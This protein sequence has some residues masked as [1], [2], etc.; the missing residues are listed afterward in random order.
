VTGQRALADGAPVVYGR[1]KEA[2]NSSEFPLFPLGWKGNLR[3]PLRASMGQAEGA[4]LRAMAEEANVRVFMSY[5]T[6]PQV[7]TALEPHAIVCHWHDGGLEVWLSTQCIDDMAADIA[8]AAGL[9]RDRV[10]VHAEHIGGGFGAKANFDAQMLACI[11]LAKE[12]QRPVRMLNSRAEELSFAGAR[13]AVQALVSLAATRAGEPA[14]MVVEAWN[15]GGACVGN[16]TGALYRLMYPFAQKR[17]AEWDV[18]SNAPIARAMRGPGGPAATFALESAMDGLAQNLGITPLALRQKW[19]PS[20]LRQ[21]LYAQAAALPWYATPAPR[22]DGRFRT[23]VGLASG[24]WPYFFQPNTRISLTLEGGRL[25]AR[26]ATQDMGNGTRTVIAA[27]IA[28]RLGIDRGLVTV[29]IGDSSYPPGPMSGGSRTTAS[30]GPVAIDATDQLAGELVDLAAHSFSLRNARPGKGGVDHDA[31]QLPWSQVFASA[32]RI[33]VTGRRKR[34]PAGRF[35]PFVVA[36]VAT[37]K[38]LA[39]GVQVVEVEVDTLLGRVRVTRSWTGIAC[40]RI[41]SPQLAR[42]QVCGG[43]VQGIGYAL[44]EERRIDENSGRVVTANLEDYRIPGIADIPAL[45]VHFDEEGFEDVI[46]EGIGMSELC[47]VPVSAAVGNAIFAATG[48][49]PQHLPIRPDKVLRFPTDAR[50]AVGAERRAGATDLSDRRHLGLH[51]GEVV[52]LRDVR[53]LRGIERTSGGLDIG[54]MVTI[55]ELAQHPEVLARLPGLAQAAG[56]LATPQIRAV[57]TVGG[58]LLQ[59]TRCNHF[60]AGDLRCRKLGGSGC[61][62]RDGDHLWHSIFLTGHCIAPHPST[63]AVALLAYNALVVLHNGRVLSIDA[64][65]GDGQAADREH[66]L[67]VDELLTGVW[68]PDPPSGEHAIWLRA[69]SRA[70]AEWPLVEVVVRQ[71]T[72]GIRIAA[73]GVSPVPV[74]LRA[75]EEALAEGVHLSAAVERAADGHAALPQNAYKA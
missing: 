65:Y 59:R 55:R 27:T 10:R 4:A 53:G 17:I 7:H 16:S 13:P 20:P 12:A 41:V 58:N 61:P 70:R 1:D 64:L 63:L 34:D 38:R 43:V 50:D 73:G 51:R 15:D 68:I 5:N 39:C 23:G 24:V 6:E 57:A 30:V 40:G 28:R 56:G 22:G 2:P 9:T 18:T 8:E 71:G 72:A 14:G 19:D 52:D 75:V 44:Y 26:C 37:G 69:S 47:T 54:A 46:G 62:A 67:S 29:Q 21:R 25:F 45:D 11:L 31:G 35:V 32:P 33:S 60:R 48:W 49:A 3:G 36:D 74:R 42:S 66:S